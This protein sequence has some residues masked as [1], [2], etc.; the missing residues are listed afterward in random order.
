[1]SRRERRSEASISRRV[2]ISVR[3]FQFL[4][5]TAVFSVS[6]QWKQSMTKA[7][8]TGSGA[9]SS[10]G[11]G[12][13][14]ITEPTAEELAERQ[15]SDYRAHPRRSADVLC[16]S[17]PSTSPRCDGAVSPASRVWL[18]TASR[19]CLYVGRR[20]RPPVEPGGALSSPAG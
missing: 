8:R 14:I 6:D 11:H 17:L 20:L 16:R 13:T 5:L 7:R 3:T 9:S 18:P 19:R 2:Q 12:V 1:L 4:C 15:I 10:C